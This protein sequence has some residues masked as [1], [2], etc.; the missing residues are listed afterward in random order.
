MIAPGLALAL[1]RVALAAND[2]A[3]A[4]PAEHAEAVTNPTNFQ[5]AT[6]IA[7]LVVFGIVLFV[8]NKYAWPPI[9]K[10]LQDREA[11]IKGDIEHAQRSRE[12]AERALQ[13]YERALAEAR[14]EASKM[15]EEAKGEQLRIAAEIRA[16]TEAELAGLR[17]AARRDI[18]TA[19]KAA[20]A[21]V[22]AHMAE[23]ATSVA[24]RILARELSADDQRAL[25]E[26]SLGQLE[27]VRAN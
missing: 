16:K 3:G 25:V 11:K 17:D 27:A 6:F 8:L 20:V 21:E 13:D 24:A 1:A 9:V 19:R 23:T 2:A 14:G 12:Q 10:A 5:A 26:E 15:L 22:Y 7:A 4:H 18:E